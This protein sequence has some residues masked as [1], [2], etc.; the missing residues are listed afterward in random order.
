MASCTLHNKHHFPHSHGI[1]Y[2]AQF[3]IISLTLTASCTLHN[4][5]HF[6][7]SHG[8]TYLAQVSIISLTLTASCTLHNKHHFLH[9]HFFMYLLCAE[10][11]GMT[12]NASH[13]ITMRHVLPSVSLWYWHHINPQMG[14]GI[15]CL[16]LPAASSHNDASWYHSSSCGR[17]S[18]TRECMVDPT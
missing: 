16:A 12:S 6:P 1:T 9:S 15:I 10:R 7:R 4:K 13:H 8:F 3:S 14:T 5:H 18:S 17:E 2:L 11:S